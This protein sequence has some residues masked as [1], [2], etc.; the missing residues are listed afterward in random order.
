MH[1]YLSLG[2]RPN[3]F[4]SRLRHRDV[5]PKISRRRE[6]ADGKFVRE[7]RAIRRE[8]GRRA[9][10]EFEDRYLHDID[11]LRGEVIPTQDKSLQLL[12]YPT[13]AA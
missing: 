3:T 12:N 6:R 1:S 10:H 7:K 11:I 2:S 5:T 13:L 9:A 8:Y 4:L